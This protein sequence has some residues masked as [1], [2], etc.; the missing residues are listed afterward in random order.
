[1]LSIFK[2]SKYI[3]YGAG[4]E[5]AKNGYADLLT[6]EKVWRGELEEG[7]MIQYWNNPNNKNLD[8]IKEAIKNSIGDSGAVLESESISSEMC[9]IFTT[10]FTEKSDTQPFSGHRQF[11]IHKDEEGCYRFFARAIDRIWP[12]NTVLNL[13]MRRK[14]L[15][16]KDYLMIADSTWRNLIKN[17]SDFIIKNGGATKI[18]Q[19]EMDRVTFKDFND[20]FYKTPVTRI[21]NIPQYK[22]IS[23]DEM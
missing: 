2:Y 1:M 12:S 6:N 21:G 16:V 19:P 18:M 17:V 20:K 23:E 11:G 3:T 13:S 22:E 14:D 5:L 8:R 7:A 9:W 4:R 10:I 15:A